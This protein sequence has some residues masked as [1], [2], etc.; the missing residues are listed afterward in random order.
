MDKDILRRLGEELATAAALPVHKEKA[1]LWTRLNDL[2]SARPMV[3]ITE[4]PWHEMNVNEE[5]TLRCTDPWARSQEENL[6]RTLYQWKHTRADMV[7]DDYLACPLVI[8]DTGFGIEEDVDIVQTSEKSEIYSR[9]FKVQI[10]EEKDLSKIKLPVITY[11]EAATEENYKKMRDV[12]DG[13]MPV[14]KEGIKHIWYTPWDNL[15]RWWGIQE[16]M[17]DLV[18]R[19]ELVNEAVARCAASMHSGLD[20]MEKLNLLSFGAN[21][22]RIGSGG[23]GYASELPAPRSAA[24][25]VKAMNNWGCSNAQIFSEVSPEMH[26]EFALRHDIP[27]LER[28]GLNYYGCCEPL[29]TKIDILRRIPRLRKISMNY[30]INMDRAV[31]NVGSDYVFSYKSHPGLMAE[32]R[33]RPEAVRHELTTLL[34]KARDHGCHVEIIMKDISTVHGQPQ[35]LWEWER[36]AMEVVEGA[37]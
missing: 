34:E 24:D 15:V 19:P 35:R 29:D 6:R 13:L 28:W 7:L 14:R 5:L 30:L 31:K 20:Q 17:F 11:D 22:T 9:H 3:W 18:D 1:A 4:L 23:Y 37:L 16:A 27:W 2:Q 10:T 26:W 36:I 32:D 12:F 25:P 21:N 33:W 8:H